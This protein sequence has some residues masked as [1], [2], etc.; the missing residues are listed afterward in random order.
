[1]ATSSAGFL[2]ENARFD[3]GRGCEQM[4]YGPVTYLA[5]H[6]ELAWSTLRSV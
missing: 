1:V 3:L 5:A 6:W 4:T 2:Q